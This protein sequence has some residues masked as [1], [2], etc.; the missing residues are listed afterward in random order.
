MNI[1]L[2]KATEEVR[3]LLSQ[4][5][6]ETGELPAE[7]ES[8]RAIVSSKAVAVAAYIHEAELQTEAVK[9]YAKELQA[10]IKTQESRQSWL[11]RYLSEHMEAA[12]ITE[13]KDERGGFCASLAV[14]RDEA[15]EVFDEAQIPALYLREIPAKHEPDKAIIKKAIKDGFEVP[16][17]KVVKKNRLTI[18]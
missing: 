10:K 8:A 2:H 18:K 9:A 13:V 1:T 12:G 17:A 14:G 4:I 11:R 5:D 7:Y 3:E 15:I 6:P 16:G